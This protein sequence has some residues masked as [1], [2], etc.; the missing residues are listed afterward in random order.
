MEFNILVLPG[1][2]IGPEVVAEAEKILN[3]LSKNSSHTFHVTHALIGGKAI[4]EKGD[5]FPQETHDLAKKADSILLGAVGGPKWDHL[6]M[7]DRPE[8]GLLRI[9]EALSL[10][11]NLR[12]AK[13]FDALIDASTLKPE[14]VKN[15]DL[16]I[17]RELTGDV[18]FAKPRGI[19]NEPGEEEYGLNTMRYARSEIERIARS[20]FN[21]ARK[22][23]KKVCSIDKANVLEATAFWRK[24]VQE[25]RD[26]EYAD[27]E[28]SHMYVDNAAMQLVRNPKQFDVMLT[29]NMFGDILSDQASMLTGSL[30]MLASASLGEKHSLYEPIHG[31]AP[32][33]AGQNKANPIATILS[34][35]M[36]FDYSLNLKDLSQ[37]IV[38][39]VDDVLKKGYRTPDIMTDGMIKTST[40][41]M[42]DKILESL[43]SA[44][45]QAA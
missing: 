40:Q 41:E 43:K 29:P 6:A 18:Y 21:I 30:G 44:F 22:R 4:D 19:F 1:D 35:A 8:K 15:L 25:L 2:G 13:V 38:D 5:P 14:V 39:A 9:R 7:N 32:D 28:L 34:L 20:A 31:S 27:I 17:L 24:V 3:W 33:I 45:T 16:M 37:S 11:A 36:M 23:N 10:Y 12:P 26:K 42:G